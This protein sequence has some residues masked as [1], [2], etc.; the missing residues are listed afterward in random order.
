MIDGTSEANSSSSV[1]QGEQ[2][3]C[4]WRRVSGVM[5]IIMEVLISHLQTIRKG[6]IYRLTTIGC[7]GSWTR[8]CLCSHGSPRLLWS[9]GSRHNGFW[10]LFQQPSLY[11]SDRK[12]PLS[13]LVLRGNFLVLFSF[14]ISGRPM[15]GV[16]MWSGNL[17]KHSG[18]EVR[19][20]D[21]L[22][23]SPLLFFKLSW[24]LQW[25]LEGSSAPVSWGN[26][27]K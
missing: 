16:S 25:V 9:S 20:L 21:I 10:W 26:P 7:L 24:F 6:V 18:V 17:E 14:R 2:L 1:L 27:S 15:L 8:D 4:S 11:Q 5:I 19:A 13:W 12:I 22:S 23:S 3:R